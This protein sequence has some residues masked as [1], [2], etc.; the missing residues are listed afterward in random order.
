[1][2]VKA[3]ISWSEE[4]GAVKRLH[5]ENSIHESFQHLRSSRACQAWE[6]MVESKWR[7]LGRRDGGNH[8]LKSI[9]HSLIPSTEQVWEAIDAFGLGATTNRL[10]N[11]VA[12][13]WFPIQWSNQNLVSFPNPTSTLIPV[14]NPSTDFK[15]PL[16]SGKPNQRCE[17]ECR[18]CIL[19][20]VR[21]GLGFVVEFWWN[22]G[23]TRNWKKKYHGSQHES[24]L[25]RLI[26]FNS[27][28]QIKT[29]QILI[30][31]QIFINSSLLSKFN[32]WLYITYST[33]TI[34][35]I[36]DKIK[37]TQIWFK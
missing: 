30:G 26:R 14:R 12:R 6:L 33:C 9:W 4:T 13:H 11:T 36:F 2:S 3:G 31:K 32:T 15:T 21:G 18:R 24:W 16:Q 34:R 20:W 10:W 19:M 22:W 23:R 17:Q 35:V 29:T 8:L 28:D 25:Y 5:D 37:F 1:M 27:W 7:M